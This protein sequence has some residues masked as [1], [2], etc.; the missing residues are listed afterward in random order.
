MSTT[1][2][3]TPQ[4]LKQIVVDIEQTMEQLQVIETSKDLEPMKYNARL[5][6]ERLYEARELLRAQMP[7][8]TKTVQS[9]LISTLTK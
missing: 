4:Q 6:W 1:I 9:T 5:C 7:S 8:D 2:P 3:L